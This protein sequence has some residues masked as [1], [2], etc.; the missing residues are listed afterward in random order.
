MKKTLTCLLAALM[1]LAGT[2]LL[3]TRARAD[4]WGDLTYTISGGKVTI[5]DCRVSTSGLLEIPSSIK[6]Y[7]V[8]GIGSEAFDSCTGLTGITIPD[9]VTSIGNMAFWNC[10]GLTSVTIP[11]SVTSIGWGAFKYCAGLR[12]V[13]IGSS[14]VSIGKYAFS[15]CTGLKNVYI[16]DP[17]A[18][19][20]IE[21]S[22]NDANPM[23]HGSSLHIL[24]EVGE[25]VTKLV[26]DDT[27]K[28]IPDYGFKN[29]KQLISVMIPDSVTS[30][31]NSA[32]SGC[33]ELKDVYYSGTEEQWE[34]ILNKTGNEDIILT[35][36]HYSY[37][38][39]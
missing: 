25:E 22:S 29:A 11:D 30:I 34:L 10:T 12:S 20:K 1:V 31:G 38:D 24:D 35:A 4:T 33:T 32:L 6:G 23:Y 9:G 17:V 39:T 18:W 7:P 37:P 15:G 2:L 16:T 36:I 27:V 19:C 3:A 21:F 14:V 5:K 8:T 13:T 28:V 26:L